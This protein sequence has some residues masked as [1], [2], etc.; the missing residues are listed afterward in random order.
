MG[1]FASTQAFFFGGQLKN[2][3]AADGIDLRPFLETYLLDKPYQNDYNENTLKHEA[4]FIQWKLMQTM[5]KILE[6]KV[7]L[8]QRK[9]KV[10]H[11]L[12]NEVLKFK[13]HPLSFY[14]IV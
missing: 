14:I 9:L 13:F 6:T 3:L 1:I 11:G 10:F 8:Y 2:T 12:S 5:K 4:L 7:K